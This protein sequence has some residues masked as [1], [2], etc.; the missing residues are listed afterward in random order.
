MMA[1][2]IKWASILKRMASLIVMLK[3]STRWNQNGQHLRNGA[4]KLSLAKSWRN[5]GWLT[6]F[7]NWVKVWL[8]IEFE[9]Q[10]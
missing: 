3:V 6:T 1:L 8:Q 9:N 7:E 10:F 2:I 5:H 4:A